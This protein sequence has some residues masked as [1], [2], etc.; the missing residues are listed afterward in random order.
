MCVCV[1]VWT[2]DVRMAILAASS[3]G[4]AWSDRLLRHHQTT[5]GPRHCQGNSVSMLL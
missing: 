1:C 2:V 4:A 5:D 3:C